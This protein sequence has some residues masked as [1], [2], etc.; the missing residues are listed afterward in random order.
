MVRR[1]PLSMVPIIR[2]GAWLLARALV[3]RRFG[4]AL[5]AGAI[6]AAAFTYLAPLLVIIAIVLALVWPEFGIWLRELPLLNRRGIPEA[7]SVLGVLLP[8]IVGA[9]R[10]VWRRI[11]RP[12]V[13]EDFFAERLHRK[14]AGQPDGQQAW[15][16]QYAVLGHTHHQDIQELPPVSTGAGRTLYLNSGTWAPLW[17][18]ERPDLIGR[19]LYSFIRFTLGPGEYS[20]ESLL[21]D[22]VARRPRQALLLTPERSRHPAR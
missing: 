17:P 9:V 16:T 14:L 7:L 4:H 15:R 18:K 11:R 13:G 6:L 21:W 19:A 3:K 12:R 2:R 20:H 8:F 10:D 5:L 1:R 22:D